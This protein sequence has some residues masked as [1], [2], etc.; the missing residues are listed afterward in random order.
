MDPMLPEWI[1]FGKE[2]V[3][4]AVVAVVAALLLVPVYRFGKWLKT[5]AVQ[6]GGAWNTEL[7]ERALRLAENPDLRILQAS[8]VN[9]SILI[10][11]AYFIAEI[12]KI[13]DWTLVGSPMNRRSE[14][15]F[16]LFAFAI[17]LNFATAAV[18]YY[19]LW[20]SLRIAKGARL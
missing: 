16:Y 6:G 9:R 7:R 2:V 19:V 10:G 18:R 14:F 20:L 12:F 11:I 3:H 1:P 4:D 15:A 13:I 17:L 8:A 5:L